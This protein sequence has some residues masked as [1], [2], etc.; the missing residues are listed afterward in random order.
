MTQESMFP[1]IEPYRTDLLEVSAQHQI[2]YEEVGNPHG[3]PILFLHGGPGGSVVAKSRRYFD[4]DFYRVILFDQRG[5]GKSQPKLSLHDNTTWHLIEDI[6]KLR[7]H[8]GISQW[9][10]F[11]GSW[12]STLALAYATNHPNRVISIILRGVFLG[13][14]I[15][16]DWLYQHGASMI[17][18]Q[19][20]QA[21]VEP[22]PA[23]ERF[24]MVQAYYSRL[25]STMSEEEK[26]TLAKKWNHWE[27]AN[28]YLIPPE[29]KEP[30]KELSEEEK[31]AKK[32]SELALAL[33]ETHYFVNHSFFEND[34]FILN[35]LAKIHHIPCF[36]AQ[37]Q[38]DTVCPLQT[39][40]DVKNHYPTAELNIIPDGGHVGSTGNMAIELVRITNH[41]KTLYN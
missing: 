18:P 34:E 2:Y 3:K 40:W 7:R 33:I 25:T 6:E 24:D 4:P 22:I 26:F 27:T 5:T 13:R 31:Y 15:E 8:L 17:R 38:Y 41:G 16:L 21:F 32:Q 20:W 39:A 30:A 10:L 37:G 14:Q 35:H 12:G 1:E 19:A 29:I 28:A 9:S 11:G 36:I 23:T